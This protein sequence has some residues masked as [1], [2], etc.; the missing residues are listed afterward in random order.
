MRNT[1]R[2]RIAAGMFGY[3]MTIASGVFMLGLLTN[4]S[5][6]R[7]VWQSMLDS[8]IDH[9]IA[10]RKQDPQSR[11][12]SSGNL[13]SYVVPRDAPPDAN[14]PT[15]LRDLAPGLHD[16]LPLGEQTVAV[17]VRDTSDMRIYMLV[18]IT[19]LE[20]NER[21]MT[22]W[23]LLA[24]AV[25]TAVLAWLGWWISGRL[26]KPLTKFTAEIDR[27]SPTV[28]GNRVAFDSRDGTEIV[29][30]GTAVNGLL[31]RIEGFVQREREFINTASH[32]L[33]TPIAA[34]IGAAELA[35]A[36]A[37]VTDSLRR[38]IHRI[39]R[40]SREIDQLIQVLLVLA[41]SPERIMDSAS[42]FSLDE[43]VDEVVNDHRAMTS[44]KSLHLRVGV[45]AACA[46]RAPMRIVQVAI[47]NLVRNAIEHS[48]QGAITV[49]V[50]PAGVVRV[51]DP[52]HG[53]AAAEISRRYAAQARQCDGQLSRGIGLAL[54]ARICEHLK[55]ELTIDAQADGST[56]ATLDL[57]SALRAV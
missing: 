12:P 53:M 56:V 36:H 29:A 3:V 13:H 20:A 40:A 43:L 51:Q 35:S 5:A 9:V 24:A 30:I 15:E 7:V 45:L 4:E 44:A 47:A 31:D 11:L 16:D 52:G 22:I 21:S 46:V 18:D 33:R 55:F 34:I 38:P 39:Q 49:S 17:M 54:M 8:E 48:D 19:S 14:F 37:D 27:L 2:I 1:L 25:L 50:E 57:R 23:L 28:R 32:E 26:L 41:K 10:E 6:E 42:E